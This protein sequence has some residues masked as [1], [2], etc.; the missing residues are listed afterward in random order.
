MVAEVAGVMGVMGT[1]VA[2]VVGVEIA[3]VVER[4]RSPVIS[5]IYIYM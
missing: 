3:G 5:K 4:S 1:E 2:G